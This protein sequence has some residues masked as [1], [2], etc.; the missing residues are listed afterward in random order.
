MARQRKPGGPKWQYHPRSD[1]HSKV[2]CLLMGVDLLLASKTLREGVQTGRIACGINHIMTDYRLKREKALD[3][4]FHRMSG[5]EP[6]PSRQSFKTLLNVY[7][8]ELTAAQQSLV[9]G[10]PDVPVRSVQAN[11]VYIAFEAKACMTE[12]GKARPRLYDE[13]NSSHMTVHGDTEDA[14]AAGFV[15]V[16][17]APT[18]ISP[19]RNPQ[20]PDG[21][22][23]I[24][25]THKQ[26]GEYRSVV[27]KVREL[28]PRAKTTESGFDAIGIVII[29]C[30]NDG[31]PVT[32]VDDSDTL[33]GFEY[34]RMIERVA[35]LFETR[36]RHR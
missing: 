1:H 11:A 20:G 12:F 28:P 26:P 30:P 9:Q 13:L 2:S 36:F 4:V 19:V 16:N 17:A 22:G 32:L 6:G 21:P 3:L 18:F 27:Q 24:V 7:G 10:L 29:N 25:S 14:I 35:H 5:L 34:P 33:K 15:L 31:S 8:I 23:L